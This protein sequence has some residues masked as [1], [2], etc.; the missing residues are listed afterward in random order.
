VFPTAAIVT[1]PMANASGQLRLEAKAS[2]SAPGGIFASQVGVCAAVLLLAATVLAA[3]VMR[4]RGRRAVVGRSPVVQLAKSR[5]HTLQMR[6]LQDGCV[7]L[8]PQHAS[9]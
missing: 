8:K 9:L 1:S 5:E 7:F 6:A 2:D 4:R 3:V